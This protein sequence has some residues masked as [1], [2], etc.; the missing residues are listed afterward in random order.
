MQKNANDD[1]VRVVSF[2][3]GPATPDMVPRRGTSNLTGGEGSK[4]SELNKQ[5]LSP[6]QSE[7]EEVNEVSSEPKSSPEKNTSQPGLSGLE[8][9][10]TINKD[11]QGKRSS[12]RSNSLDS[13]HDVPKKLAGRISVEEVE[14]SSQR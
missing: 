8:S 11:I 13:V 1:V 5:L 7:I 3:G 14:D 12:R 9:A 10:Q 2:A 4:E 6:R